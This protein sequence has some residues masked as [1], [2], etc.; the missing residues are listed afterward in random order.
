MASTNAGEDRI[1]E[2]ASVRERVSVVVVEQYEQ[3]AAMIAARMAELIRTRNAEGR[4]A[5]LG[6]A[7]GSTPIG[8]Y[9]ELIRL[10]REEGLDFTKVI[11]FNLDEYYP[12][13]P[14]SIHSYQRY[15]WENLFDHIN[16][17]PENVHIPRGDLPRDE[18]ETYTADYEQAIAEAGGI[19]FQILG[20]GKTGHIGFNEPG[21]GVQSRTR[22]VALDTVT[23]RDAAADFF[24]EDSVPTEAI[25]MGVAT[26][27]G[28]REV[29]LIATGEHK[30]RIVQ[31]AAEGEIDPDVAATYLQN[32]PNATFYVDA[33]AAAELTR[34]KTPWVVG[35]VNWD[36]PLEIQ[37]VMWLSQMTGKSILKLH[38]QD[39]RDHHLSSLL[40]RYGAAGPLNGEIFNTLLSKIRGKSRLPQGKRIIVFSPHPDDDVISAG[41]I[42]NKLHQN[43]NQIVVAYQTSGNI[44]VF[45]HE[46]RRHMDFV[47][48]F[49]RD[50]SVG[51]GRVLEIMDEVDQF[52]ATKE[53]GQVDISHVQ[54]IKKSIREA[55]AVAGIETFGM[56]REQAC[57]LNLPFYQT[58]KVKKDEIGPRDVEITLELLEEHRPEYIFVAGDLS[59]PHGTH[60]M[61][62]E[63]VETA[64]QRYSGPAPEVWYYRGA[65][66]EWTVAEADVLV[67]MSEEELRHKILAIFKH[68]S[69]K[70]KAPF[71]GQDD[72]EFWQRVEDRNTST[73]QTVDLLGLPEYYAMEAYVVRKNGKPLETEMISTSSLA[74]PPRMRRMSDYPGGVARGG[75]EPRRA[76]GRALQEAQAGD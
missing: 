1:P 37:A 10:H 48:R 32:H 69:Q 67:P 62:L 51:G 64:L 74:A 20:I 26:I 33:A 21:S 75:E 70:D 61:C 29:A 45:D 54:Q 3:I 49:A 36:R 12:M 68:Q 42:L 43:G 41:G 14:D 44:A 7:T 11:T 39:Y 34:I 63:A 4:N 52:L 56:R 25:T 13:A 19:D 38:N 30:A 9:R 57:F 53:P 35:E 18:V 2:R 23:R 46:V 47:R 24:G 60:R 6:L 5:V 58:G 16:I 28:A 71:P 31:R 55:E 66:Q 8:V 59:D 17:Q 73:A 50:F 65:W 27:L 72:R 40:A 22:L 15:M 76:D